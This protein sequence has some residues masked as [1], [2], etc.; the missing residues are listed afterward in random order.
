M[1]YLPQDIVNQALDAIGC[2]DQQVGDLEEGTRQAQVA[3][4][5][6]GQCRQQLL[7]AAH[8]DFARMT[9]PLTLLADASGNTVDVGTLV[10]DP[11]FIYEY[12]YPA[13]CLKARFIPQNQQGSFPPIPSGNIQ[14][15]VTPLTSAPRQ[16]LL[17]GSR[18]V[19]ARFT[20]AT[21]VNYP[22]PEGADV[23]G[24]PGVSPNG[25]TVILTNVPQAQLVYTSD[26]FYPTVW[27]PQ[28]RAALVAYIAAELA[29]PMWAQKDRK[30]GLQLRAEQIK[31]TKE[32]ITAAR[33]TDGNEGTF[34]SDIPVDWMRIR[35][36]GGGISSWGAGCGGGPGIVGFGYDTCSFADGSAY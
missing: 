3:L 17:N 6:Y 9:A 32:K 34:S 21:D 10:V 27:D 23:Y 18:I 36:S 15:P 4:R 35:S 25:R 8:W 31:I 13:T 26:M 19:P 14:I 11:R 24:T 30:F 29:L 20:V 33:I 5:A 7:R 22:P 16:P 2:S 28:F 12:E 1:S